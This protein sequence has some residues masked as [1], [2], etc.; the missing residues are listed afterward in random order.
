MS[1]ATKYPNY[2]PELWGGIE[3]TINRVNDKYRDQLLLAGHYT[4]PGDIE[5]IAE[6]GHTKIK[7]SRALGATRAISKP[8]D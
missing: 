5:R 2:N 4:R 8:N 1:T 7:I 6:A 3:C